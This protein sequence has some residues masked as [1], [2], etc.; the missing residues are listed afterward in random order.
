MISNGKS[1]VLFNRRCVHG[2]TD[3]RSWN[4]NWLTIRRLRSRSFK[5]AAIFDRPVFRHEKE[6]EYLR[7]MQTLVP[8]AENW[9]GLIEGTANG[10]VV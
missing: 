10:F 3:V 5:P 9:W 8:R 2:D 4:R 1:A 6:V 7:R